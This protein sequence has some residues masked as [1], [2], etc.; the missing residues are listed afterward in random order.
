MSDVPPRWWILFAQVATSPKTQKAQTKI[1]KIGGRWGCC[2]RSAQALWGSRISSVLAKNMDEHCQILSES[3]CEVARVALFS[4]RISGCKVHK[5]PLA[6][7]TSRSHCHTLENREAPQWL[8][9][10]GSLHQKSSKVELQQ[11]ETY[12]NWQK[13]WGRL[14]SYWDFVQRHT[15]LDAELVAGMWAAGCVPG[16]TVLLV[17]P[18]LAWYYVDWLVC[19]PGRKATGMGNLPLSNGCRPWTSWCWG[20]I[21]TGYVAICHCSIHMH[22]QSLLMTEYRHCS[23]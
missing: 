7:V 17:S 13:R 19:S 23:I 5:V 12:L 4:S 20:D 14:G 3:T 16:S 2:C 9:W 1:W 15:S 11:Q 10:S 6:Q 21:S 18:H 22:P 8:R